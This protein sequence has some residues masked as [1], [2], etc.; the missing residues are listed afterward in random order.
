M[1]TEVQQR[2]PFQPSSANI[3]KILQDI[4]IHNNFA[5]LLDLQEDFGDVRMRVD[6]PTGHFPSGVHA[7]SEIQTEVMHVENRAPWIRFYLQSPAH[8][9]HHP[10]RQFTIRTQ[11]LG[12]VSLIGEEISG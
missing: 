5:G 3:R 1:Y 9:A 11:T 6:D 10:G 12:A 2:I 4:A 7:I 8:D